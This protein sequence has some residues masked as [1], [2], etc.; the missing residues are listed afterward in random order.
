[1]TAVN[2]LLNEITTGQMRFEK[3]LDLKYKKDF[4]QFLT[5]NFEIIDEILSVIDF[6][7]I[8]DRKILEPSCGQGIFLVRIIEKLYQLYPDKNVISSFI[9][10]N[11]YFID[12]DSEMIEATKQNI[13]LVYKTLFDESYSTGFNAFVYDFTKKL[14]PEFNNL[15]FKQ[16]DHPL[17]KFLGNIDYIIGNPPYVS[18][19]GRRDRKK[20]EEQRIYYLNNYKQF[21]SNLKNG[22]INYI[23]LFLEHG[24]DFLRT[25]GKLSYIIDIS[26]FETAYAHTRKYLL[27]NSSIDSIIYNINDFGV[28]S[29]QIILQV[30]KN[31]TRNNNVK[32]MNSITNE[33]I[34]INQN[35]WNNPKDEYKFRF[36]ANEQTNSIIN[37]IH[38]KNVPTLK[39]LYPKKNLRTCVMLLS[40]E[41]KFV[42][43]ETKRTDIK[44]YPYYQ[45]SKSLKEK[46]GKLYFEK[47]FHYDKKL[48]DKINDE[49]KTE[50]TKKG[51]KN[52][53]RLGLGETIIYDNPKIFIRQSAKEI[54]ATYDNKPSSANN[55]LY[56]FSLRDN[57]ENIIGFLKFL[58]GYLNSALITFYAQQRY[59]IRYTKGKQPQI[60]VSDLYKIPIVT[61]KNIQKEITV[62][63][64]KI[65]S[66]PKTKKDLMKK[67]DAIIFSFFQIKSKEINHIEKTISVFL[68]S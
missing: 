7:N 47:Y 40:M 64:D 46:Y 50:L 38:N 55:S 29:G 16:K 32:I 12:I 25:N 53:K 24:L 65:Y 54:I 3:R 9:A 19:Y 6:K 45:G 5:C 1:M 37:K 62:L 17:D 27:Y 23:M 66:N 13:S 10:N 49:L 42:F 22:K 28:A 8:L 52:K 11:L 15:F 26:F 61:D 31:K 68:T 63:V 48:Q 36:N 39:Q 57:S 14:T 56:V 44:N 20:N 35:D 2:L 34:E 60:K 67:I 30:S 51:I 58:T 18:L 4:G 59:I 21:P 43:N 41:N 33:V